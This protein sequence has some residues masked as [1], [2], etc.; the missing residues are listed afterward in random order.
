[1]AGS[2]L[3]SVLIAL[4]SQNSQDCFASTGGES[5]IITWFASIFLAAAAGI[6]LQKWYPDISGLGI[7]EVALMVI[8]LAV[9]ISDIR[10]K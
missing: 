10:R 9:R 7:L 4:K 8:L 5:M 2:P 6:F 1:V 3:L